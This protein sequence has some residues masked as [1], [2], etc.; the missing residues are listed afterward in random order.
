MNEIYGGNNEGGLI[1]GKIVVNVDWSGSS[2]TDPKSIDYVYGGGFMANYEYV[3]TDNSYS[4]VVNIINGRVNQDVFGG[5]RNANVTGT[6]NV[7]IKTN[8][9][10]GHNVYGGGQSGNVGATKVIIGEKVQP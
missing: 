10:I 3:P 4:P 9:T 5:G 1:N 7:N 8:A 6:T 2:C